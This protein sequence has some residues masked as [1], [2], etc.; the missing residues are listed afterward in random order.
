MAQLYKMTLYVCDLEENMDLKEIERSI[1]E[2]ALDGVSVN[3]L[4]H[5]S[6]EQVGP[7]VEWNENIDLNC[8]D[9]GTEQWEEYFLIDRI[10]GECLN[11]DRYKV[12]VFCN[13]EGD[14]DRIYNKFMD[15]FFMSG[16]ATVLK[17]GLTHI[18]IENES[19]IVISPYKPNDFK[20]D[21]EYNFKYKTEAPI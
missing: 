17:N 21:A 16:T 6:D 18:M 10:V 20:A 3:C 15:A 4:C 2:Y 12:V 7:C 19:E 14:V 5:F 13:G 11:H 9:C 1:E 8:G